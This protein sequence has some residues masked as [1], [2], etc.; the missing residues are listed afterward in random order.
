MELT[1]TL[2][3]AI[4]TIPDFPKPGISFKD[5][6]PLFQD[7]LLVRRCVNEILS[8]FPPDSFDT[9]GGIEARGLILGTLIAHTSDRPFFPFR[10]PGKLPWKTLREPY[11]LEYGKNALE[12][13]ADAFPAGGRVL[14][15]DDLLATGGTAGAASR[16][17]LRGGGQITGLAFLVELSYLPGRS[18]LNVE[19]LPDE[20]IFSLIR[21][22]LGE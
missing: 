19:G 2:R 8:V 15:V 9:V 13:H 18:K 10:K 4:R 5:V 6:T 22:G 3:T 1:E 16:L 12:M 14:I 11:Q 7:P 17:V 21:F 20:K